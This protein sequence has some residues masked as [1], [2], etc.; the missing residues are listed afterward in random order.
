MIKKK[1]ILLCG[2]LPDPWI[3]VGRSL[4][5]NEY[6]IK[7]WIGW[8]TEDSKK[9]VTD[10]F[11]E[12]TFLE[13][14]KAWKG[15]NVNEDRVTLKNNVSIPLSFWTTLSQ[16]IRI[17][18][19]M[20]DRLD[21]D[22]H[23]FNFMQ[24][25]DFLYDLV[26]IWFDRLISYEIDFVIFSVVPH[27]G[28][29]YI[30]Y[31]VAK[32]LNKDV[33]MFKHTY[34]ASVVSPIED[35]SGGTIPM[36]ESNPFAIDVFNLLKDKA[37][38]YQTEISE[39]AIV[40]TYMIEQKST[41]NLQ[42]VFKSFFWHLLPKNAFKE[43]LVSLRY[44]FK[45]PYKH[46]PLN[47][48]IA[49]KNS[50]LNLSRLRRLKAEYHKRI[51]NVNLDDGKNYFLFGL[52]YQPEETTVPSAGIFYNQFSLIKHISSKLPENSVLIV[53]EHTTQFHPNYDGHR[54]RYRDIYESI[55]DLPNVV[56]I[57]DEISSNLLLKKVTAVFTLTG[58][59]GL[60]AL[61]RGKPVIVFGNAWC[62]K[63][64]G[65]IDIFGNPELYDDLN[66]K[67]IKLPKIENSAIFDFFR[68][69]SK[70]LLPVYL[71]KGYKKFGLNDT[72]QNS[73]ILTEYVMKWLKK[74]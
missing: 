22:G 5:Q 55:K 45:N 37:I 65:V 70:D 25:E 14:Y 32:F 57:N 44:R 13:N 56:M 62:R 63:I 64:N 23:S 51:T 49:Y 69:I 21:S 30:L 29:D 46:S 52:H 71:Y 11:K 73:A 19:K 10:L 7:Y 35:I 33:L 9:R 16:E 20:F 59:I 58:T 3:E 53:K 40:P 17:A 68:S 41:N 61:L 48:R 28:F 26:S 72:Q 27:R 67:L 4:E 54:G 6:I 42:G 31:L 38:S 18:L 66:D 39:E 34:I 47:V 12:V 60:E 50:F 43:S 1:N 74:K 24:R 15:F 2:V 36:E 8:D